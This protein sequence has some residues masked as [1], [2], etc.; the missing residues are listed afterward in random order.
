MFG[1]AYQGNAFTAFLFPHLSNMKT[2]KLWYLLA[3]CLGLGFAANPESVS[4]SGYT[5]GNTNLSFGEMQNRT[6]SSG[7]SASSYYGFYNTTIAGKDWLG[8]F[9]MTSRL[10]DADYTT[11]SGKFKDQ[12]LGA[13][14]KCEGNLTIRRTNLEKPNP[15]VAQVTW[16]VKSG[17]SCPSIGTQIKLTLIES[18][19]KPDIQGDFTKPHTLPWETNG[20]GMWPQWRVV[21]SDGILNCRESPNGKIIQTYRTGDK[22]ESVGDL[23]EPVKFS[24]GVPW[25]KV[26]NR[27][28]CYIRAN[29]R[30]I[31]PV[32]MPF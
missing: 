24:N 2:H 14:Q 10:A 9:T 25:F 13:E 21:S 17:K 1:G 29:S 4:A 30:Y 28:Y 19:P 26:R 32:S 31:A 22:V 8:F 20:N 15:T 6:N 16:Q 18:I 7:K 12:M 23:R 3:T 27:S 11:F 5:N